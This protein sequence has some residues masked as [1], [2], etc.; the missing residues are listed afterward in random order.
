MPLNALRLRSVASSAAPILLTTL[1]PP[2]RILAVTE[3]YSRLRGY[4]LREQLGNPLMWLD[5]PCKYQLSRRAE[6]ETP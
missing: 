5:P 3:R 4:H 2:R 6:V 1:A